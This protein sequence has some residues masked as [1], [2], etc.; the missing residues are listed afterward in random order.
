MHDSLG[1]PPIFGPSFVMFNVNTAWA[2]TILPVLRPVDKILE[3][4]AGIFPTVLFKISGT[5]SLLGWGIVSKFSVSLEVFSIEGVITL[6]ECLSQ[7]LVGFLTNSTNM[8]EDANG[9]ILKW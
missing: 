4:F 3:Y 2:L 7:E 9:L 1:P 6:T 8:D 5:V